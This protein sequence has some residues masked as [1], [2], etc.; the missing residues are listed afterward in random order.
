MQPAAQPVYAGYVD[1]RAVVPKSELSSNAFDCLRDAITCNLLPC[2]HVLVYP[3]PS[4]DGD[5]EPGKRLAN[6]IWHHNYAAGN[7]L[8]DLM[9]DREGVRRELSLPAGAVRAVFDPRQSPA[10]G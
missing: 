7:E 2:G 4:L 6:L 5:L 3:I 1:W 8:D 9:T 10:M